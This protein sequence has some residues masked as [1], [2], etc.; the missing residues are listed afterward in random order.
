M[1]GH[2]PLEDTTT[3]NAGSLFQ[4]DDETQDS[5]GNKDGT[6]VHDDALRLLRHVAGTTTTSRKQDRH[7]C[8]RPR[9]QEENDR[10]DVV[11]IRGV[12]KSLLLLMLLCA[13]VVGGEVAVDHDPGWSSHCGRPREIG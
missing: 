2:L 10:A 5:V 1:W 4:D 11:V 9:F 13:R 8:H 3:T 12:G 6:P 7:K